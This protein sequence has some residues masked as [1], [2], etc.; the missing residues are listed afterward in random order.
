V[1]P[2]SDV[3]MY[4][5]R[6]FAQGAGRIAPAIGTAAELRARQLPRLDELRGHAEFVLR[7]ARALA[8]DRE[9]MSQPDG[10]AEN[11]GA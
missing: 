6:R 9:S 2:N 5:H 1:T 3:L 10:G 11:G 8:D 7:R 4:V